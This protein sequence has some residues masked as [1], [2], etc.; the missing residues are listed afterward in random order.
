[1]TDPH[2]EAGSTMR[3]VE[4]DRYGAAEE[5]QIRT[6]PRPTPKAR[7]A[8][9]R[10]VGTT[11]NPIDVSIRSGDMRIL[12]GRKFPKRTGRDFTGEV[13]ALGSGVNDLS[14]GQRV[15]GFLTGLSGRVGTAAEY[16]TVRATAVSSAP[17]TID[18]VEAAA[19]PS[20]GVTA[21]HALRDVLR[22][23]PGNRLLIVGASGGVGSVAIQLGVAMGAEVTAASS[24]ANHDFCRGLGAADAV[25]YNDP[26]EIHG[27]YD[28]VL[29]CHG[30]SLGSYRRLVRRG[31]RIMTL[32]TRGMGF[33][34][35]SAVSPGPRIRIMMAQP[36]RADLAALSDYVDQKLIH[37]V[38]EETHPLE[39]ITHLHKLAAGGHGRG[40]RVLQVTGHASAV[41]E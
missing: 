28:A 12:T 26:K 5:L 11:I 2:P 38:V 6:V 7:E 37:P 24:T 41:T 35:R 8:L 3:A 10:V 1:M 34:L 25:D 18:P 15:W 17:M 27:E 36:R 31:G 14:T 22:V 39:E 30:T 9:V 29:D 23:R 20:V 4:Y 16:I 32:A 19:L 13:I 40:K 33:A 21:L